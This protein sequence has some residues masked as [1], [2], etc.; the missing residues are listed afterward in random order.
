MIIFRKTIL[1]KGLYRLVNHLKK[2]KK[3]SKSFFCLSIA[4][5]KREFLLNELSVF[6]YSLPW[7]LHRYLVTPFFER[8]R[9]DLLSHHWYL[10]VM[11]S[12]SLHVFPK[13]LK[14]NLLNDILVLFINYS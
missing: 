11:N 12:L 13:P 7:N 6:F 8:R 2:G 14:G 9:L 1:V 5:I 10:A 3:V 4:D